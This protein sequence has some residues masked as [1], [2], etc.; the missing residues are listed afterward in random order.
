MDWAL[1]VR[2]RLAQNAQDNPIIERVSIQPPIQDLNGIFA[3][4]SSYHRAIQLAG[5][6]VGTWEELQ[7]LSV[8]DFIQKI[9]GRNNIHFVY[10]G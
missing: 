3:C 9:G 4:L 8:A 5:G 6:T 1:E 7:K 10:K 2:K